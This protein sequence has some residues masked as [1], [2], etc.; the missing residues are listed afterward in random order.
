M[1][2]IGSAMSNGISSVNKVSDITAA[3][4]NGASNAT[5]VSVIT[6]AEENGASYVKKV[7]DDRAG[8]ALNEEQQRMV[9][10]VAKDFLTNSLREQEKKLAVYIGF[11]GVLWSVF[12]LVSKGVEGDL[13]SALLFFLVF[14]C[15]LFYWLFFSKGDWRLLVIMLIMICL[16]LFF[17]LRA[18][19][20]SDFQNRSDNFE[21]S[22][23]QIDD[24][25]NNLERQFENEMNWRNSLSTRVEQL[26][27]RIDAFLHV[28][29]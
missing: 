9:K 23:I 24:R 14:V 12:A 22:L 18:D 25:L 11:I 13:L 8:P 26:S 1:Q 17:F 7:D 21:D 28:L 5:K 29:K 19:H 15:L 10:A 6:A 16:S 27:T 3:E 20:V 4:E 2:D